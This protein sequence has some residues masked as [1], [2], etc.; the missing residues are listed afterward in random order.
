MVVALKVAPAITAAEVCPVP[1][2][3]YTLAPEQTKVWV[4]PGGA[5]TQPAADAVSVEAVGATQ[6]AVIAALG[7]AQ[8]DVQ[9]QAAVQVLSE[10]Q[11]ASADDDEQVNV[12][13]PNDLVL[14]NDELLD[15]P[16][17]PP[18]AINNT[19]TKTAKILV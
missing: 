3:A 6:L 9:V 19:E 10:V 17:P 4:P 1:E 12:F 11:L 5:P 18:H 8:P 13:A 16:L 7:A 14:E 15:P 2:R